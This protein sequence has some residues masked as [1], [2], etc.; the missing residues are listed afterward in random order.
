MSSVHVEDDKWVTLQDPIS[1]STN[2]FVKGRSVRS[3]TSK[4]RRLIGREDGGQLVDRGEI[5]GD[6]PKKLYLPQV[7]GV[8]WLKGKPKASYVCHGSNKELSLEW[9]LCF[10]E[11]VQSLLLDKAELQA[12]TLRHIYPG[13]HQRRKRERKIRS[14]LKRNGRKRLPQRMPH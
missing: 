3:N 9:T 11:T 6:F 13:T 5:P 2:G 7:Q 4:L 10:K 12:L 14:F 1:L 8:V